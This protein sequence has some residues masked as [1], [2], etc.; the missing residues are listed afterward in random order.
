MLSRS[1]RLTI[2]LFQKVIDEGRLFHSPFFSAKMIKVPGESRFAIAV[3]KKLAKNA[4]ERNKIRRR[5]YSALR[6]LPLRG[7]HAILMPKAP[8]L[9]APYAKVAEET[10]ALFVKTGLLK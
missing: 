8:V 3:S 5:V 6:T 10:K 4:T 2:P 1:Q 9:T 7:V